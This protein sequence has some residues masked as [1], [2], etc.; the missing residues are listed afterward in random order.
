MSGDS[1]NAGLAK[2]RHDDTPQTAFGLRLISFTDLMAVLLS[3]FI[4]LYATRDPAP[5]TTPVAVSQK[6]SPI[7][8]GQEIK[9]E[10]ALARPIAGLDLNYIA[11]LLRQAQAR[12]P[13]LND[14][15]IET[16]PYAIVIRLPNGNEAA[17]GYI[18][19]KITLYRR[20]IEVFAPAKMMDRL[21]AQ[22]DGISTRYF[23]QDDV[24]TAIR[25]LIH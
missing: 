4:L 24:S 15:A 20:T 11:A 2:R 17:I 21:V 1:S 18:L 8:A 10:S 13:L 12:D 3:F 9:S 14:M 6:I 16:Q 5:A 22:N 23:P 19:N 7:V 25:I